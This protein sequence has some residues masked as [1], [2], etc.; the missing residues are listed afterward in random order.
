M[1]RWDSLDQHQPVCMDRVLHVLIG[2]HQALL[3]RH[4]NIR[5]VKYSYVIASHI[6]GCHSPEWTGPILSVDKNYP[7]E[8]PLG[9]VNGGNYSTE[10]P[11]GQVCLDLHQA[12]KNQ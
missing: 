8:V 3:P 1:A 12:D 10:I 7:T 2:L 9:K 4:Y 5:L 11:F 6:Q